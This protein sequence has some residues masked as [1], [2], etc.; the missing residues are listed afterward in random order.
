MADEGDSLLREVDDELRREQLEKLWKRYSS[1]ILS[2]AALI[3]ASV[4]GYQFLE[5]RRI[6]TAES[7]G[8]DFASALRLDGDK[9]ADDA[10]K[11]FQV[12]ADTGPKGYAALAKLH[13][14][15]DLVKAGKADEAL[16]AYEALA[17]DASSD[18][19]L[20]SYAQ[21]QA[22]SLRMADAGWTEIQNRLTPLAGDKGAFKVSARELLGVAAYKTGK[23][24]EARKYLEPLLI[25]PSASRAIQER[26]K[27]LMAGIAG[28]E[29]AAKPAA[30]TPAA[31]APDTKA[32]PEKK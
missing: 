7:A 31:P 28:A 26:I 12:I 2:G 4:G 19:L 17:N 22:A 6:T 14:A 30:T 3:V 15:G 8:S 29:M 27:I 1:V 32:E 13:I 10:A 20:K 25:D 11:S 18:E 21:L 9:K 5:H 23:L 16:K 24:D